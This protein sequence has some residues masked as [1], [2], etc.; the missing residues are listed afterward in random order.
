MNEGPGHPWRLRFVAPSARE[1]YRPP[2][3]C[4]LLPVP[5]PIQGGEPRCV[6]TPLLREAYEPTKHTRCRRSGPAL[7]KILQVRRPWSR[8]DQRLHRVAPHR[9][10]EDPNQPHWQAEGHHTR[11]RGR[12]NVRSHPFAPAFKSTVNVWTYTP[13]TPTCDQSTGPSSRSAELRWSWR[14]FISSPIVIG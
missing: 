8:A 13:S 12:G 11:Q 10:R 3:C 1:L 2:R 4:S 7:R 9:R 14:G 5:E 6:T